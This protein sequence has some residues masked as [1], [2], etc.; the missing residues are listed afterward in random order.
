MPVKYDWGDGN[1]KI[2]SISLAEHRA[3]LA[4]QASQ[5]A[6]ATQALAQEQA[7]QAEALRLWREGAAQVPGSAS[8]EAAPPEPTPAEAA[9]PAPPPPAPVDPFFTADDLD[10]IN[11]FG[12]DL[13]TKLEGIDFGLK[14]AETDTTYQK[15][16]TDDSAKKADAA[17]QDDAISRGIFRSSIKDAT[18]H[19]IEAQRSLSSKFLDLKL[20]TSRLNAGTNK[21]ILSNAKT[22]FDTNM[23]KR[24]VDNARGVNDTNSSA[25]AAAQATWAANQPV[26]PASGP[27]PAAPTFKPPAGPRPATDSGAAPTHGTAPHSPTRPHVAS[28][29]GST[30]PRPKPK[31]RVYGG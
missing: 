27:A 13:A 16:Q 10:A 23:A 12:T 19:D 5:A 17:A 22:D 25:W 11:Q 9:T 31:K 7:Q 3:N 28:G 1:G 26:A 29:T 15:T 18:I 21:Q 6:A 24:K 8:A 4:Q 2:H 14:N 20:T 30:R